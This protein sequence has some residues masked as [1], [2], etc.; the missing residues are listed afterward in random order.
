VNT[1][2]APIDEYQPTK[3]EQAIENMATLDEAISILNSLADD[4]LYQ[5]LARMVHRKHM[6]D[7]DADA[8]RFILAML[9]SPHFGNGALSGLYWIIWGRENVFLNII[10]NTPQL[11]PTALEQIQGHWRL[12]SVEITKAIID[13][14]NANLAV[15]RKGLSDW[16]V[17]VRRHASKSSIL[18]AEP[19]A[20]LVGD[21]DAQIRKNIIKNPNL[22]ENFLR[23]LAADLD[24]AVAKAAKREIKKR[25]LPETDEMDESISDGV[26]AYFLAASDDEAT[27]KRLAT[28]PDIDTA[29]LEGLSEH[30]RT[31]AMA[32]GS[33]RHASSE[34][35]LEMCRKAVEDR[36][37]DLAAILAKNP[38]LTEEATKVLGDMPSY[39]AEVTKPLVKHPNCSPSVI[40]SRATDY[41]AAVR[42]SVLRSPHCTEDMIT[43]M[44][45]WE[46]RKTV[47]VE[48]AKHEL[49]STEVLVDIARGDT[50]RRIKESRE[51]AEQ[52]LADRGYTLQPLY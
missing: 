6:L 50:K 4:A 51:I 26:S 41:R 13:H 25:G 46:H 31:V 43:R 23:V 7:T 49:T 15:A 35:L 11:P 5:R 28:S 27:L 37:S 1:L 16:R 48:I 2:Y 45:R 38:A 22:D 12:D 42:I 9:F 14:P 24:A 10:K 36:D 29:I 20:E 21:S 52:R 3:E 30:S 34:F 40:D 32:A 19:L 8:E 47:L 44:S 18:D 33:N 39:Y 17:S